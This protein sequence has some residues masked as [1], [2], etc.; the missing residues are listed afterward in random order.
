M[1]KLINLEKTYTVGKKQ[2][3]VLRGIDLI[4]E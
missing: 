1:I 4:V 3:Y 2:H